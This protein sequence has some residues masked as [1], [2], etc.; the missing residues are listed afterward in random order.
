VPA[1]A[2][3]LLAATLW[4]CG[5]TPSPL[6]TSSPPPTSSPLSPSPVVHPTPTEFPQPTRDPNG[7]SPL[8]ATLPEVAGGET[9]DGTQVIDGS[10]LSGHPLDHVLDELHKERSDAVSVFRNSADAAIGATTVEG[11]DGV[12][13]LEAFVAT[14]TAPAVI[15]RRQRVAAG[16]QAWELLDRGGNLTV[17]YRLGDVV[18]LVATKD[19]AV[20]EAILLDMP[21]G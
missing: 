17:F 11:I 6:P 20:L 1:M 4:A 2:P 21:T 19:R 13:L 9:F 14:W 16:T 7:A 12:T 3:V 5:V 10:F 8:L 15:E 18:Y